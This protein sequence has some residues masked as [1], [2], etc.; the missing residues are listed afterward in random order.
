M[1]IDNQIKNVQRRKRYS[2][3]FQNSVMDILIYTMLAIR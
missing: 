2:V 3:Y 1:M